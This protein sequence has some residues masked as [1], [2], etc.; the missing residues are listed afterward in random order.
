MLTSFAPTITSELQDGNLMLRWPGIAG[1]TYQV[2]YSTNLVNWL[3][4]GSSVSG[5]NG[6]MEV[7]VP[8][9]DDPAQ[10]FRVRANN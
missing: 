3:P 10:Y 2:F 8:I 6:V 5:S 9:V 1:L 7:P 4:Y